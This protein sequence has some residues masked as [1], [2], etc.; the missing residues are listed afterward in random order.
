MYFLLITS[1]PGISPQVDISLQFF[2]LRVESISFEIEVHV[3]GKV[4]L[5][6]SKKDPVWSQDLPTFID[7]SD[8]EWSLIDLIADLG[9]DE[10]PPGD[11]EGLME[12]IA[13]LE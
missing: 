11:V 10:V 3:S 6:V 5:S 2:K 1:L 12:Q 8:V 4:T 13:S 9:Q 7:K